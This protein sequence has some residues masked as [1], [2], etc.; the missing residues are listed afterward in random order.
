MNFLAH[1]YLSFQHPQILVGNMIGDF[2]KGSGPL[3][4][5]A[6]GIQ[7]GIRL[8][9]AI[10]EFADHHPA[11]KNASSFFRKDYGL[12]GPVFIDVVYDHFLANDEQYFTDEVLHAFASHTYAVMQ[13]NA[14]VLPDNFRYVFHYMQLQNW[15]YGYR[16]PEGAKNAFKGIVRRAKYLDNPEA[17]LRYF[18][19]NYSALQVCY[20]QFFP[21]MVEFVKG[22]RSQHGF[23]E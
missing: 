6:P 21:D 8:H 16:M 15:L 9:R 23:P 14:E 18:D 17:A 4:N 7:W 22:Y 10:D 2:V 3:E 13:N 1:A 5:Y 20:Q 11:T 19:E 12:Y